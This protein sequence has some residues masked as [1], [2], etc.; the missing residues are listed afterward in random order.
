MEVWLLGALMQSCAR[1]T[2][3]MSAPTT[4]GHESSGVQSYKII[5]PLEPWV[6][7]MS[8]CALSRDTRLATM[9]K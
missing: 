4:A 1:M 8:G 9:P 7:L 2:S 3:P 5:E 6:V